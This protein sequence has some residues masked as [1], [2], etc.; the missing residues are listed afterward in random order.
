MCGGVIPS[1][2]RT[3]WFVG[4]DRVGAWAGRSLLGLALV[5]AFVAFG[6]SPAR[7]DSQCPAANP[8]DLGPCG[9]TFTVP[10]WGDDAGWT[11]ADQ[12]STIQLADVL[13]NGR[14]QLIAKGAA[15]IEIYNFD[16][17]LGQWR[18][19]VNGQGQPVILAAFADPPPSTTANPTF[20]GTDWTQPQYFSSIQTADVLANGRDQIIAR[21]KNGLMIFSYTPGED[22]AAGSWSQINGS[23]PFTDAEGFV[24]P[25]NFESIHNAYLSGVSQGSDVFGVTPSGSIQAWSAVDQGNNWSQLPDLPGSFAPTDPNY[26]ASVATLQASPMIDGEQELWW[27]TDLGMVGLRLDQ[28]TGTWT[29]VPNQSIGGFLPIHPFG[30]DETA[31]TPWGQSP[32]YYG[33]IRVVNITGGSDVEIAG[34]GVDGLDVW[35]L[36]PQGAWKQLPTLTAFSDANGFNQEKYWRTI[37]YANVDGSS[38]G[39]QEV[40]ARG[41]NGIVMYKYDA[42]TNQWDQLPGSINLADDP[43]GSDPSYYTTIHAGDASGD[44]RDDTLI[45]RGPYGIRTWFYGRPGQSGWSPYLPD[46]YPSFSGEQA[47]A[48]STINTMAT[49]RGL[50]LPGGTV[51]GVWSGETPPTDDQLSFLESGLAAIG[52]CPSQPVIFE[53]PTYNNCQP[54]TGSGIDQ[55]DWQT[56][57]NEL[58]AEAYDAQQVDDFFSLLDGVRQNLFVGETA[59]LPA[60]N[61][62]VQAIQNASTATETYDPTTLFS[63]IF[64][65]LSSLAYENSEFSAGTAIIGEVLSL[66]PSASPTLNDD[67][68]GDYKDLQNAFAVGGS[69]ASAA[70]QTQSQ[71]VRSNYS[72]LTLVGQLFH[73]KTWN[74]NSDALE[75]AGREGFTKWILKTLLPDVWRQYRITGCNDSQSNQFTKFSCT[76]PA[77][78]PW[79]LGNDPSNLFYLVTNNF[80]TNPLCIHHVYEDSSSDYVC[81]YSAPDAGI[82]NE[83]WGPVADN[84]NY[85]LGNSNTEWK[86]D[87]NLGLNPWPEQDP[88]YAIFFPAGI[89]GTKDAWNW[90]QVSN[91]GPAFCVPDECGGA[92][93]TDTLSG[94]ATGVGKSSATIQLKGTAAV[95]HR[96]KLANASVVLKH[97]LYGRRA[98]G[99]LVHE[100]APAETSVAHA[101]AAPPGKPLGA[102][103]LSNSGGGHFQGPRTALPGQSPPQIGLHLSQPKPKALSIQLRMSNISVPNAPTAC[104][105]YPGFVLPPL[106]VPLELQ[107]SIQQ[108]GEKPSMVTLP[109]NFTCATNST[110]TVDRLSVVHHR[111]QKLGKGLKIKARVPRHAVAGKRVTYTT[112]IRNPNKKAA[113][114]V[115]ISD[116]LF[117]RNRIVSHTRHAV[118]KRGQ[119]LWRIS[120]LRPRRSKT[121]KLTIV[122]GPSRHKEACIQASGQASLRHP[123]T[124]TACTTTR[125]A[126]PRR[127]PRGG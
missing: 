73:A 22:G 56:V 47:T 49:T 107:F 16:T 121:V 63:A 106:A 6:G 124:A 103:P 2:W 100:V 32:A 10:T 67:V 58:L 81:N 108:K 40:I 111:P 37:Q 34:R 44:G 31:P 105:Y 80:Q 29:E 89:P 7:A 77:A 33:T 99:E 48:Y 114:D 120:K 39:Q 117:P 87:C 126:R 45:G 9:P 11:S 4:R 98:G 14:D 78:G 86:Y 95:R 85:Q 123:A 27:D 55:S 17:G 127:R 26:S 18:P 38:S 61:T 75:S 83:L 3:G 54:P 74:V 25:T 57:V 51:R 64:S 125:K 28:T 118:V 79:R 66:I 21:G 30:L 116:S 13:G 69:E 36:S 35:Q 52:N 50:V 110:G 115:I 53:P 96:L 46:G 112:V 122:L 109:A 102:L 5:C 23:G 113:V 90:T 60:I 12:Y 15:G 62:Q 1:V 76:P 119:I 59:A 71:D 70:L 72:L 19:E 101:A 97:V 42:A 92:V 41:P 8:T 84:C 65:V 82:S 68:S 24:F 20:T 91:T 88:F 94:Q 93:L 43:W 104:P